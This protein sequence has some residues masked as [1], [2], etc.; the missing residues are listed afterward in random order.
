[1]NDVPAKKFGDRVQVNQAHLSTS[2]KTTYDYIVC[3]AG[4]AG[5]VVAARLVAGTDT[6]VLVL[7]AGGTDD[8]DI[9]NDPNLWPMTLGGELDWGFNAEAN[10]RLNNRVVRYSMGKA[11]GGG[12]TINVSTWSRG[13]KADWDFYAAESGDD[14]W[15]YES[16]LDIY[17]D[18]VENWTGAP[19]PKYRGTNG[20][21]HVQPPPAPHSFAAALLQGAQSMGFERFPN[22]NGQMMETDGGCS[23]VDET[24]R[25]G[26]RQSIFRAYLQP[27]LDRKNVTVL[28]GAVVSRIIFS[29]RRASGIEFVY[30]GKS[31]TV[32]ADREI[33]LSLGAIHTPKV[34]M[35]SGIGDEKDLGK[36]QIPVI[37]AL[38]GVGRNLHD[39]VSFGVLWEKT[40]LSP[41]AGSRSQT[42]AFW[43]SAA[44]LDS[45]DFYTYASQ[46]PFITPENAASTDV[47]GACWSLVVGMRPKSRGAIH[48]TGPSPTDPVRID[49]GYL[50]DPGDL[51]NLVSGVRVAQELGRSDAL[52]P[53][54]RRHVAPYAEKRSDLETFLRNGLGTFWHQCGTAKMGRDS[55]SVVDSKLRV[56]GI[57]GLRIADASVIP[58]VTTGNTMAPC[59]IVG[60]QAA[61]SI[62]KG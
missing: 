25:G 47:P 40:E 56:Y 23:F 31:I 28:T 52:K 35:Q 8:L 38:P 30:G 46:H 20:T 44:N 10:P 5:C 29:N 41:A 49:A 11:L 15:G 1:M 24:V 45:P 57:E 3:G 32:N 62:L 27:L 33:V 2:L 42:V 6:N 36:F 9:T 7:E 48:L 50:S 19:D 17:R 26:K 54:T 14:A 43:T 61:E 13:H 22:P 18:R 37:Q 39:H 4:A 59:V 51:D 55:M 34:L 21:V 60:E 53:F 58:R 16:V 12:S